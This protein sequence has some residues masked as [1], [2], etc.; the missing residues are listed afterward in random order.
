[1]MAASRLPVARVVLAVVLVSVLGSVSCA[2]MGATAPAV[3]QPDIGVAVP[4]AWTTPKLPATDVAPADEREAADAE[5]LAPD[6]WTD[7]GDPALDQA[8]QQAL[9][10]NRDLVA[11]ASRLEQAAADS[12]IAGSGLLPTVQ[13]GFNGS[14]RKQN[15]IGFP[16]P[17]SAGA[18]LSTVSANMG[19]SLDTT[20]DADLWGRLRAGARASLADLQATAAD[21]RGAQLSIAGQTVKA[22]LAAVEARQQISLAEATVV[23]FRGSSEQVRARFESGLRSSLDVRLSLSSLAGAEALLQQRRQQLDATQ[24]QLGVLLGQYSRVDFPIATELPDVPAAVPAGLPADLVRRRPDLVAAERRLASVNQQ[25]VVAERDLYPRI[26]L[27][28]STGTASGALKSLLDPAFSVWSLAGSLL[29]PIFQGGRLRAGVDRAE[30]RVDESLATYA[31]AALQAYAEVEAALAAEAFFQERLGYLAVSAEQARSAVV[32]AEDRYRSGLEDFV[33]VLESQRLALQA[34]GELIAARRL[35]LENRVDLYLALGG[36][37]HEL[38]APV[39][40]QVDRA[41]L[42]VS[43]EPQ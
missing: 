10:Q 35:L 7:F 42:T 12:R 21:Y 5:G 11:A 19:V 17:G 14:R 18:V 31:A 4:E 2:S 8:V 26:S 30:A 28:G 33:T 40:L 20:W 43:S 38:E 16:I 22:W 32:L 36:G 25:L 39:L 1:M 9:E 6:W 24:R 23:S 41:P 13:V 3:E 37:F 27:T 29:Q 34:D 15:F